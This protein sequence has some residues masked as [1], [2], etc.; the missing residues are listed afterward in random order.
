M[1]SKCDLCNEE[2]E[3][4]R[5][6][7]RIEKKPLKGDLVSLHFTCKNTKKKVFGSNINTNESRLNKLDLNVETLIYAASPCRRVK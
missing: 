5:K 3:D 4:M 1:I 6:H 7:Y 2:F